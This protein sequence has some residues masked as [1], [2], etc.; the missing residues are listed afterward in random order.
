MIGSSRSS[1]PAAT[2][3]MTAVAVNSFDMDWTLKIVSAFTGAEPARSI[4]P[5]PSTHNVWSLSTRATASPGTPCSA[6]SSGMR[7]RYLAMTVAALALGAIRSGPVASPSRMRGRSGR[8]ASSSSEKAVRS[9]TTAPTAAATRAARSQA[10]QR[11]GRRRCGSGCAP[12]DMAHRPP[13]SGGFRGCSSAPR[14]MSQRSAIKAAA[15]IP[16]VRGQCSS[17]V[18][19][20]VATRDHPLRKPSQA[21]RLRFRGASGPALIAVGVKPQVRLARAAA[22]LAA[23]GHEA[24]EAVANERCQL[25]L[26]KVRVG[27]LAQLEASTSRAHPAVL[28]RDNSCIPRASRGRLPEAPA[29]ARESRQGHGPKGLLSPGTPAYP[30][31]ARG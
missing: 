31:L 28:S 8:A 22:E 30:H 7:A 17:L 4:W 23:T 14:S 20:S 10:I 13:A 21:S 26:G 16:I 9:T 19:I 18:S 15:P 11:R 3:C 1:R 5:K 25:V 12:V 27:F 24:I 2:A 29:G 6:I